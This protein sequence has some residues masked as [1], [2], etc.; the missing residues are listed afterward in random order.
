MA[1]ML[2]KIND[3]RGIA[4]DLKGRKLWRSGPVAGAVA[5]ALAV[6]GVHLAVDWFNREPPNYSW[7]EDGLYLGGYAPKPPPDAE[8]VL[9]LCEAEDPYRV[10]THRWEPIRDGEPAPG[11]EWLR[12]QVGFIGAQRESG[13]AVFVH[14]RNGV[15]RSGMVV[16]AYLMARHGWSRDDALTFVR[17]RREMVRPNPAF[18]RLLREWEQSLR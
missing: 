4:V 2:R 6:L 12:D 11:L 18:M 10:A 7:I 9:N 17:S 15:S 8:A 3:V 16:T 1:G 5:A 14:C 13:R